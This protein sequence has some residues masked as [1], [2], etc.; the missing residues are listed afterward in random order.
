MQRIYHHWEK[1]ECVKSGFY[2]TFAPDG[3]SPD[4]AREAY[5]TFLADI[6]RF[7]RSM[8]RVINEWPHSCD[9]FFTNTSINR[10]AWMGQ[11]A[12]CID[13][14]VPSCF[15]GG[16]KLLSASQQKTAN[17]YAEKMIAVWIDK[18]LKEINEKSESVSGSVESERLFD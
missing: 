7:V 8:E 11:A 5:K 3:M 9:Q 17:A 18:K 6:P 4:E 1:W 12:M 10:I 16:F 15:R 14:G 2:E 13:T